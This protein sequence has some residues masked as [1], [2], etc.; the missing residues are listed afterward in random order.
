MTL[1]HFQ[2]ISMY[3]RVGRFGGWQQISP[4]K[5]FSDTFTRRCA[6]ENLAVSSNSPMTA[7]SLT[8][9]GA[10]ER[11]AIEARVKRLGSMFAQMHKH[12]ENSQLH[13]LAK[14][15]KFLAAIRPVSKFDRLCQRHKRAAICWFAENDPEQLTRVRLRIHSNDHA[16]SA[17]RDKPDA[18]FDDSWDDANADLDDGDMSFGDSPT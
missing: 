8:P 11:R 4:L 10:K 6:S 12:L 3:L 17:F 18:L 9:Q 5:T 1:G 13:E 2:Y 14:E 7:P 15:A 16:L